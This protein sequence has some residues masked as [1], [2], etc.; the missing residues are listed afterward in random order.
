M[1]QR[2][3]LTES[4]LG[5]RAWLHNVCMKGPKGPN[6]ENGTEPH[7]R[8]ISGNLLELHERPMPLPSARTTWAAKQQAQ[9]GA[10]EIIGRGFPRNVFA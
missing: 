7:S 6:L 3:I 10:G 5:L 8:L 4:A 1:E 9:V 2:G